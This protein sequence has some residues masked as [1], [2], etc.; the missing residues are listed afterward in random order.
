VVALVVVLGQD[1]PVRR[2]LVVVAGGDDEILAAIVSDQILQIT[3]VFLERG[4]VAALVDEDPPLP[5][6]DA[7]FAGPFGTA[8]AAGADPAPVEEVLLLPPQ[9]GAG[10]VRLGREGAAAAEG[11]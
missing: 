5:L 11:V 9:Y 7:L 1:L 6:H 10:S 2:D 4:C 8:R 3:R